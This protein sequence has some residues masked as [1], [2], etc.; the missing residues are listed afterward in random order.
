[1]KNFTYVDITTIGCEGW[2]NLMFGDICIALITDVNLATKIKQVIENRSVT[3]S[4]VNYSE[5]NR[6]MQEK[7]GRL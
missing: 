5:Q 4:I 7:W 3:D 1:M 2:V 6:K